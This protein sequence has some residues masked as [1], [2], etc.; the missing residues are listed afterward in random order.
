MNNL[1][2]LRFPDSRSKPYR[3]MCFYHVALWEQT[4]GPLLTNTLGQND[5]ASLTIVLWF[6][7]QALD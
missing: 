3:K 1:S 6:L 4:V 7:G 5:F 2:D